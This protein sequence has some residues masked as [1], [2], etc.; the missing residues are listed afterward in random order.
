MVASFKESLRAN[1]FALGLVLFENYEVVLTTD[2]DDVKSIVSETV[3][4]FVKCPYQLQ[5]KIYLMVQLLHEFNYEHVDQ[6]LSSMEER[7]NNDLLVGDATYSYLLCN[8]N[9]IQTACHLLYLLDKIEN[10]YSMA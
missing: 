6:V 4:A 9:A 10:R 3:N 1:D 2:N 8:M 5:V 7:F